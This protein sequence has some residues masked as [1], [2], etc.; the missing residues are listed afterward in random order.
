MAFACSFNRILCYAIELAV[1]NMNVVNFISFVKT[2]DK[3]AV[4][5]LLARYIAH[6]HV[7]HSRYMPSFCGFVGLI[8]KVDSHNSFAALSHLNVAYI[9]IFGNS[10]AA[11]IGLDSQY[12]VKVW[13]IHF[14]VFCKNVF[15]A[16]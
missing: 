11:C 15:D 9:D 2:I 14:A 8:S 13:R 16:T 1:V 7:S 5:A 6:V 10:S 12:T 4:F 3:N